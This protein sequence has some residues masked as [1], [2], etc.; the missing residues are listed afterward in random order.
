MKSWA[1]LLVFFNVHLCSFAYGIF[2]TVVILSLRSKPVEFVNCS[3][4]QMHRA[5]FFQG[6]QYRLWHSV[7]FSCQ[8]TEVKKSIQHPRKV[9]EDFT[10]FPALI[11]NERK[12]TLVMYF[13]LDSYFQICRIK[14]SYKWLKCYNKW[15]KPHGI[16]G[17]QFNGVPEQL[18]DKEIWVMNSSSILMWGLHSGVSLCV[19]RSISLSVGKLLVSSVARSE[20]VCVFYRRPEIYFSYTWNYLC[21]D[22][23]VL[24]ELQRWHQPWSMSNLVSF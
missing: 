8:H 3:S 7:L 23:G 4:Y 22:L 21:R 13:T 5:S 9:L 17:K 11:W 20:T 16:C 1:E 19:W 18:Q 2:N 15:F 6:G 24:T 14:I 10:M 12:L